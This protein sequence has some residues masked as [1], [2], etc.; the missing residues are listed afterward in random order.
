MGQTDIPFTRTVGASQRCLDKYLG[1]TLTAMTVD[2][3]TPLKLAETNRYLDVV[4]TIS[5][6]VEKLR[7]EVAHHKTR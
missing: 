7:E 4:C 1:R 2:W 6:R 5:N 3:E